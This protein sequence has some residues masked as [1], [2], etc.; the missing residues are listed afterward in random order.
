MRLLTTLLL[1]LTTAVSLAA[2]APALPD[3]QS[4][5]LYLLIGQSNMAGRGKVEPQD[6]VVNPHIWKLDKE[7]RWVPS[8]DPLHFDKPTIAGVGLGSS[9]ARVIAERYPE[10]FV[11]LIP[12]AVGG[13]RIDQWKPGSSLYNEAVRRAKLAQAHG[14]LKGILWHQGE[15]DSV[16]ARVPTYLANLKAIVAALRADLNAPDVPL[17]VGQIGVF[18]EKK[19]PYTRQINQELLKVDA[20]IPN[21]ACATSEGLTDKGDQTHFDS[22]SLREFG[23]RYAAEYLR[24]TSAATRPATANP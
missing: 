7:D 22:P 4:L 11:G 19:A 16:A 3:D 24:L 18:H 17:V 13:T 12:S 9:F 20:V 10:R 6:Q 23:K 5:D 14:T 1:L 15:S 8:V 2:D 21:S